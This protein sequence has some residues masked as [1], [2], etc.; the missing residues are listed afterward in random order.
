MKLR[1]TLV[2]IC[3][4]SAALFAQEPMVLS[5]SAKI[6]LMT[7]A[8][9]EPVYST[10]GHSAIRVKDPA[11]RFDRCYNYGTFDFEQPNFLLKFCRG[12]LDYMLDVEPYRSFEYGNLQ[13]RR[14][15]R[16][17]VFQLT[18]DQKQRLFD[19]IQENYKEENRY[20][21]YDFFYDNCAT[22]IRD[23]FDETFF[24]Q[25]QYD[26][27][28]LPK[29]KTM[30]QLLHQYLEEK[31]WTKFGIDLVLGLPAERQ[32]MMANF[33]FLPD[34]VHDVMGK[35]RTNT[36]VPL[37]LSERKIPEHSMMQR[38]FEPTPLDRPL[39]MMCLVAL[40]GLLSMA[41]P[42]TE[43]VFDTLF[44]LILGIAGLIMALLWFATDHSST[45]S[46]LNLLWALP[47]HLLFFYR[48]RRTEFTDLYFK[49][50]G[51]L[52]LGVLA[53]W[54]WLPQQL[55]VEAI[56]IIGLVVVKSLWR[57]YWKKEQVPAPYVRTTVPVVDKP[58]PGTEA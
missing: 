52:A 40:I 49:G 48:R 8:P 21:K 55:P 42:R 41:N 23:I 29:P 38:P 28:G 33:M 31:P 5:D 17:Q 14:M 32:A 12:K 1:F 9:G 22:R 30:R 44:W 26:S 4:A 39:W 57:Q 10:F 24:H 51:F 54:Y 7:V 11:Q 6:S 53:A 15:M 16:E 36:G 58:Q 13:D 56:P 34:Y 37:V 18:K 47:T 20:Y 27:S 25:M 3:C 2:L 46:N 19:L 43:R 50:V 35:A 45:K